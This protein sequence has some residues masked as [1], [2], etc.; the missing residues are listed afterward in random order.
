MSRNIIF[1]A[2]GTALVLALSLGASAQGRGARRG[3]NTDNILT[4]T[5]TLTG[6]NM[7]P[8]QQHPSF[9]M[10]T[11]ENGEVTILA[12]PYWLVA[13]NDLAL[14]EGS[15]LT[16]KAFASLQAEGTY[17]AIEIR[18]EDTGVA[19]NLFTQGGP[20]F[21]RRGGL[22]MRGAR[23]LSGAGPA[24][25][26]PAK[27]VVLTGTVKSVNMDYGKEFPG[28]VLETAQGPITVM[29]G[30]YWLLT[31]A[32]FKISEGETMVVTAFPCLQGQGAYAAMKLV[33][34]ATGATVELR[35]EGGTPVGGFGG[36]GLCR[37]P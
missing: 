10:A 18:N 13:S 14:K 32:G 36:R 29:A 1:A 26:D 35:N 34:Q 21:M 23:R 5:G 2:L 25:F 4:F 28:F 37:I 7:T 15:R 9:K 19:L 33:N 31:R 11:V 17:V 8:G 3:A 22:G 30:P 24:A 6:M 27:V 12:G 20:G 16:V